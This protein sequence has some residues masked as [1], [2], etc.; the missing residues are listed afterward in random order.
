MNATEKREKC[1]RILLLLG[2]LAVLVKR[3]FTDFDVDAEYALV[4]PYRMLRGDRMFLEMMEP[5]QTSAFFAAFFMRIYLAAFHTTTGLVL[6]LKVITTL[7]KL[8]IGAFLYKTA[9]KFTEPVNANLMTALF[10]V[11][12]P[13]LMQ[14]PDYS[15]LQ[16]FFTVLLLC[17][18]LRFYGEGKKTRWLVFSAFMLCLAVISYPSCAL[19]YFVAMV[20][21]VRVS[22]RGK[23]IRNGLMFTGI[24]A[25]S[26]LLYVGYFVLLY[27]ANTFLQGL[28]FMVSGDASHSE[29]M[30]EKLL[31]YG[32]EL[33]A[34]GLPCIICIV[35]GAVA[36]LAWK[37]AK[38]ATGEKMPAAVFWTGTLTAMSLFWL[39]RV[40]TVQDSLIFT[41]PYLLLLVLSIV[42]AKACSEDEKQVLALGWSLAAVNVLATGL[43][44]NLTVYSAF[45][46]MILGVLVSVIP[47]TKMGGMLKSE[48]KPEGGIKHIISICFA[49]T[50]LFMNLYIFRPMDIQY[51]APLYEIRNV[52]KAGPAVGTFSNYIG[53]FCMNATYEEWQEKIAP[54]EKVL[55]MGKSHLEYLYQDAEICG[56][57]V[58][59]TASYDETQ[60]SYW[61]RYPEKQPDVVVVEDWYGEFSRVEED[62]AVMEWVRDNYGEEYEAGKY[63]RYYRKKR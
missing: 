40:I 59:P 18:L 32:K 51:Y 37:S 54:G 44:S 25:A 50:I 2:V 22:E 1:I 53:P 27:G 63:R 6:Y 33:S 17:G 55:V 9:A 41:E 24:C 11:M 42:F 61:E 23:K 4:L 48:T 46:Y 16:Y 5:H 7:C 21:T 38:K 45:C 62:S 20:F 56:K 14:M 36:F 26:G 3:L 43:L 39:Y 19:L 28:R 34:L 15:N 30:G 52:V 31:R 57:D 60:L 58:Q 29:P 47:L 12:N 10:L 35:G 8:G 49:T 13:K